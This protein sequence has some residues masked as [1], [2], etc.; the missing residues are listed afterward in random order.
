MFLRLIL[1]VILCISLQISAVFADPSDDRP[2]YRGD[3]NY[4][5][6]VQ[7]V[8]KEKFARAIPLLQKVVGAK[9]NDANA[10]NYLGYSNRKLGNTQLAIKQYKK[11]LRI[12]P[13]HLGANEYLGELYVETGNMALARE[14]L[15]VLD[16][17]CFWGCD[18]YDDL[19]AMIEA[20]GG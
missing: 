3:P 10:W 9:P 15:A 11:A 19:K 18:E 14:R 2:T 12:D 13:D 8:K 20:K 4:V 6:A 1:P 16:K 17:A 5:A 7:L